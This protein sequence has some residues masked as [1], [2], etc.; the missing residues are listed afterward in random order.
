MHRKM[1]GLYCVTLEDADCT[2]YST[3]NTDNLE[4]A[5]STTSNFYG[6]SRDYLESIHYRKCAC[7]S[8]L[9]RDDNG[10]Y[11]SIASFIR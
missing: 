9:K 3:Y 5:I 8:I 1:T 2:I 4:D 11:N 7:V 10:D 6:A